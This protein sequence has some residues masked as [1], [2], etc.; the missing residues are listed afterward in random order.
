MVPAPLSPATVFVMSSP[1]SLRNEN[2]LIAQKTQ[3]FVVM[4]CESTFSTEVFPEETSVMRWLIGISILNA[5]C[6]SWDWTQIFKKKKGG[7]ELRD[8]HLLGRRSTTWAM[9]PS[10]FALVIS[11]KGSYLYTWVGSDLNPLWIARITGMSHCTW[12][13]K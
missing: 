7:V 11:W 8:S 3:L 6:F 10:S 5:I 13:Q 2:R 12:P 1:K 9:S 4:R